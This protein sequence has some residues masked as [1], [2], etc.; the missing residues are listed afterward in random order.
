MPPISPT[1]AAWLYIALV[2]ILGAAVAYRYRRRPRKPKNTGW[3]ISSD[4]LAL[5]VDVESRLEDWQRFKTLPDHDPR[6]SY[7][8]KIHDTIEAFKS[9]AR[10]AN[11]LADARQ[12]ELLN[13]LDQLGKRNRELVAQSRRNEE[14]LEQIDDL[15][16]EAQPTGGAWFMGDYDRA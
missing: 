14:L 3:L 10:L 16:R 2:A 8:R 5:L 11:G 9:D 12:E 13:V 4:R 15:E 1:A 6:F 7:G